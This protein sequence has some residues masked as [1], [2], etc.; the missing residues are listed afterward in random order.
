M[1]SRSYLTRKIH[2]IQNN[3]ITYKFTIVTKFILNIAMNI[4]LSDWKRFFVF[5]AIIEK[6]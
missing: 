6:L 1:H 2:F 3:V 4:F 5:V